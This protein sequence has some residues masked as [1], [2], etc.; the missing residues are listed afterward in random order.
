MMAGLGL[1]PMVVM[2]EISSSASIKDR[3]GHGLEPADSE[4]ELAG[5]RPPIFSA[6]RRRVNPRV[7][8]RSEL[9]AV[10][11][12][13]SGINRD[14]DRG[15]WPAGRCSALQQGEASVLS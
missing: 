10:I 4:A 14:R 12:T 8:L 3:C 9:S 6:E 11:S 15:L 7:N 2:L 13:R 5:D 1:S